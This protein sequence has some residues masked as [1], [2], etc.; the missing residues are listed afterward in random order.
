MSAL[1]KDWFKT[2]VMHNLQ[3]QV[4]ERGICSKCHIKTLQ[5]KYIGGELE[6]FQCSR[7]L[8]VYALPERRLT[9]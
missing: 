5:P 3:E 7:C 6:W 1:L 8:T 9:G 4:I 2:A